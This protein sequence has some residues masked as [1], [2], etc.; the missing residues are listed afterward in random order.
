MRSRPH[1]HTVLTPSLDPGTPEPIPRGGGTAGP[2]TAVL[3]LV[4]SGKLAL[5]DPIRRYLPTLPEWADA[6]AVEHLLQHTSGIPDYYRRRLVSGL[7]VNPL[8]GTDILRGFDQVTRLDF[9]PGTR[10]AESW[11][12]N[13]LQALLVE[14]VDGRPLSEFLED[15]AFSVAGIRAV[16]DRT[17]DIAGVAQSYVSSRSGATPNS[18]WEFVGDVG[19]YTTASDL[20]KWG[21]QY[22]E[23]TVGGEELQRQ[24]IELMVLAEAGAPVKDEGPPQPDE[25]RHGAGVL[26]VRDGDDPDYLIRA[27][28]GDDL[29]FVSDLVVLPHERLAAAVLCN[30][31]GH[32]PFE[33]ARGL[34]DA[35][36]AARPVSARG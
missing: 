5:D 17:P 4:Q 3:L 24:R 22:W 1:A 36:L 14:A 28:P 7:Y 26:A 35:Y 2:A 8:T 20:A 6:V 30:H 25:A 21:A 12:D 32:D 11:S 33:T 31:L 18:L 34:L 23:P 29:G 9:E 16:M 27:A 15:E 19:V 10:F 13:V